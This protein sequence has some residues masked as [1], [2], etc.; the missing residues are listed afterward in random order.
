MLRLVSQAVQVLTVPPAE[1]VLPTQGVQ[2]VPS[3]L[4]A[5]T[6]VRQLPVVGSQVEQYMEQGVQEVG[7]PPTQ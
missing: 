3:K 5:G 2:A 6:Q 1:Y 7:L 4:A